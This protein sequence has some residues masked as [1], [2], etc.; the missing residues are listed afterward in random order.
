MNIKDKLEEI[1]TLLEN[2]EFVKAH[3]LC[4]LLWRKYKAD[5]N[6]REE[7][8]I[9]KAFTNA[10][11]SLELYNMQREEHCVNVWNTYKKY[12]YLIDELKSINKTQYTKIKDLIYKKREQIIK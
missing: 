1:I 3:D 8:F 12:E 11:V 9:L 5:E 2:D 7:S 4:E 10:S 6:T